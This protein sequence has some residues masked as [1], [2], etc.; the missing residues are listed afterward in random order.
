MNLAKK[1]F[2]LIELLVVIAII[3]ILAAIIVPVYSQARKSA[4]RNSDMSSMDQLR[5][6]LQLY[7][8]DQGAYPPALLGYVT[9]YED[10]SLPNMVPAS[11]LQSA[12]YPKRVN[13]LNTFQPALERSTGSNFNA[14]GVNPVWPSGNLGG[15]GNGACSPTDVG[16]NTAAAGCDAQ[17]YGQSTP[18]AWCDPNDTTPNDV[19]TPAYYYELSGYDVA[20]VTTPSGPVNELHYSPW[21]TGFTVPDQCNPTDAGG[22]SSDSPRQL[23]YSDP[24]DTTVVTWDSWFRDYQN[25]A[26]IHQKQDIVLFLGGDARPYDSANVAAQAWQVTP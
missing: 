9:L 7:K 12:L 16:N 4:Y 8:T 3:G 11:Q 18:V 6:A 19:P 23:G 26:P 24:P 5:S 21:W 25:G 14:L 20:T 1:G 2:T 10:G 15:V 13:S 22:S 17:R